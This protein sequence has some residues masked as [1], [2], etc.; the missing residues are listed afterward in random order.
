[1]FAFSDKQFEEGMRKLGLDPTDTNKVYSMPGTGGFYRRSDAHI[2]HEMFDRHHKEMQEA[3]EADKTGEG[4]IFDMFNY[5]LA[6]HEYG[7]T[8]SITDTLDALGLTID[9]INNNPLLARGLEKARKAQWE[10]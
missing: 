4:F 8:G 9:D 6:N 7:Y 5:E 2:L 1:V 3:I 10:D